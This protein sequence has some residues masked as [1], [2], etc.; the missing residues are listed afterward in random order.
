MKWLC[1]ILLLAATASCGGSRKAADGTEAGDT[2]YMP[3]YASGFVILKAGRHSSILVVKDPWQGAEGVNI[4]VFLAVDGERP[5]EGFDGVVVDVPLQ[6]V[7]CMSSSHVAFLEAL[8]EIDIIKG[9]SGGRFIN[10]PKILEWLKD[11]RV[12]DVGYDSS[13]NFEL[14]ASL[15]PDL[16]LVYGVAGQSDVAV[17]KAAEMGIRTAYIGDY[18]ESSPLGK[19]E[20]LVAF[21][22]MTGKR[23]GAEMEFDSICRRYEEARARAAGVEHRP[24]VILNSPWRDVWFVPGDSNYM[25]SL[26][27]D[28]GGEYACAGEMSRRSRP[29][30]AETAYIYAMKS[31]FWLNPGSAVTMQELLSENPKFASIPAVKSGNVWNNNLRSTPAGGSDFWESGAVMPDRILLDLIHI[32]HPKLLPAYVPYYYRQLK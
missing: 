11:G 15:R 12:K 4:S 13:I 30:G 10:S 25:V 16:V 24:K 18:L 21:G 5:A 8:G 9:V 1:I 26:L 19:A 3:R 17:S 27:R 7:V 20:W 14:L 28:A 6:R 32:L 23:A 2:L 29:L 22:Q 31:E